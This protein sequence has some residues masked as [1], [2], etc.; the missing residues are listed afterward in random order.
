MTKKDASLREDFEE[1]LQ[2]EML[3]TEI[4]ARFVNLPAEQV[5][6]A[7]Q[8]AQRRICECLHFDRS[9]MW[10][11]SEPNWVDAPLT[12]MFQYQD[13]DSP[14]LP[15]RLSAR[16]SVPWTMQ[17]ILSGEVVT[18]S[19]MAD[20]PSEADRDREF[21]RFYH[22]K[23][24]AVIPL[25]T[26][27]VIMG[28]MAFATVHEEQDWPETLVKR[29]QVVAQVFANAIAR[30]RADQAL[31][32]SEARL[33]L[34]AASAGAGLWIL[35]LAGNHFWLTDKAR[36]L[37]GL[38]PDEELT[39]E[40]FIR[41]IHS[42]EREMIR[43]VTEQAQKSS[44]VTRAEFR[45]VLSD[46]RVRW[47][48]LLGR[49]Y[50][51]SS[52]EP[53]SLMGVFIDITVRKETER[54]LQNAYEEI[55]QLK[56]RLEAEN[57]YLRKSVVAKNVHE[58]IIGQS[59]ALQQVLKRIDQVAPTDAMVLITGETGTG[60]ELI[61]EAIHHQSKRKGRLLVKVNC[62]SLPAALMESELFGREKGAYTGALAKQIGRFELADH[63][64]LFLD[65]ITELPLDVQSKLL[66]VL[67]NGEFE[68]LGSPRTIRVDVRLIAATNRDIA[69]EVQRGTFRKDLYYRLNVFPI[70]VPPLRERPDDIPLLVE[71][72]VREFSG[73]MG[74]RI[75]TIPKSSMEALQRYQW[76]GNIR[77]LR[78]VIEHGVIISSGN[79]LQLPLPQEPGS[80]SSKVITLA[81]AEQQH[82]LE[83]LKTTGWRIKGSRGAAAVLGI[84]PSNL[85][86]KMKRLGI[87]THR[88]KGH[89]DDLKTE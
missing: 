69:T 46:E 45:I 33:S 30:K 71:A 72:F 51:S 47:M 5:E 27:G 21:F 7:I 28:H 87:P 53:E 61:A 36:E 68:R 58:Y 19:K 84:K 2:F 4:S 25:M 79:T 1:Q 63:S 29:L 57:I 6:S 50:C 9:T 77:E 66:R 54:S 40:H 85:Y 60:K 80:A 59:A 49:A 24:T 75:R 88:E 86:A 20:L 8:D 44:E 22:T 48:V 13:S 43:Q 32:E 62:A 12:H 18:I 15:E 14:P 89:Y 56:D 38:A 73:K 11:I 81:E 42:E 70:E 64:T 74:K 41:L 31:R 37:L 82:I 34:A 16:D 55:K 17:K 83:I 3:L 35:D 52:M 10:Q 65:E 23:S 67:Q 78:N 76:P 26:G 39:F